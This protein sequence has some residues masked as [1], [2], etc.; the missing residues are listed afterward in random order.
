MKMQSL[1]CFFFIYPNNITHKD[2]RL[3]KL[4]ILKLILFKAFVLF[5]WDGNQENIQN[6]KQCSFKFIVFIKMKF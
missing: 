4:V 5:K 3:L 2:W 1:K 6:L